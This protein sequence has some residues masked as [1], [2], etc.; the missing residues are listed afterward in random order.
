MRAIAYGLLQIGALV[1]L[2]VLA[3]ISG[4]DIAGRT[5]AYGRTH[6]D[7]ASTAV[8]GSACVRFAMQRLRATPPSPERHRPT[9]SA[10][11]LGNSIGA[12]AGDD[13]ALGYL[14][15]EPTAGRRRQC[16]SSPSTRRR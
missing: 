16:R 4:C 8:A 3:A 7:K 9:S 10:T 6:T 14:G 2:T 11:V 5:Q 15:P 1:A 13:H 12:M